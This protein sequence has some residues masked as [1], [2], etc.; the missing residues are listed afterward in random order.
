MS[1]GSPPPVN[2]RH[3][4][5]APAVNGHAKRVDPAPVTTHAF[6]PRDEWFTTCRLCGL[7]EAAHTATTID[8]TGE[9]QR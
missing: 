9:P 4:T 8:R 5:S 2:G 1:S 7:A 6:V 3:R